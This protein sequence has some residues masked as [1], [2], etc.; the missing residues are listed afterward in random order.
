MLGY[1]NSRKA[2]DDHCKYPRII[3]INTVTKRDSIRG[4]PNV[5]I[6]NRRDVFRLIMK[7]HLPEAERFEEWVW[8]VIEFVMDYGGYI[9]GQKEDSP[10]E[11][12][13]KAVMVAQ[14]VIEGK[15]KT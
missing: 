10:E 3:N 6:I 7:S 1:A 9:E 5:T 14:S 13:A 4:N 8:D 11:I 2:I 15:D 12:L